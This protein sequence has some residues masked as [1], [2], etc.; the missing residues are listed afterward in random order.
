LTIPVGDPVEWLEKMGVGLV[1]WVS[2][3]PRQSLV[4]GVRPKGM[5]PGKATVGKE[6]WVLVVLDQGMVEEVKKM[7]L[8][9]WGKGGR[10]HG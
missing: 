8:L 4:V 5:H 9:G 6:R 1:E 2:L 10:K 3:G 7:L